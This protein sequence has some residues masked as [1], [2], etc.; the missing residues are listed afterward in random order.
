MRQAVLTDEE[1]EEGGEDVV[2]PK[3]HS[4]R[5]K[6][7]TSIQMASSCFQLFLRP[8]F[9]PLLVFILYVNW[10]ALLPAEM[11]G[12]LCMEAPQLDQPFLCPPRLQANAINTP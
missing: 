5:D 3:L 11:H 1:A 4:L 6:A 12:R 9:H 10:G 2:C 8:E 7:G